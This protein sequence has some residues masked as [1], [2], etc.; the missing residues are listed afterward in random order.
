VLSAA[1]ADLEAQGCGYAVTS[2]PHLACRAS[3]YCASKGYTSG[4]QTEWNPAYASV[5][6]VKGDILTSAYADLEAQGCGSD[7]NGYLHLACRASR[8]CASKGYA[9]GFQTE[10]GAT[11]GNVY[12]LG[13]KRLAAANDGSETWIGNLQAALLAIRSQVEILSAQLSVLL[14]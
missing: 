13:V 11:S 7:V 6:C 1:Y 2:Y 14:K 3:R 12:C 10:W 8:Y 4:F 9:S 5:V